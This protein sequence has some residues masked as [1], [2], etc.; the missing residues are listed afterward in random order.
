MLWHYALEVHEL[1]GMDFL[2]SGHSLKKKKKSY[3]RLKFKIAHLIVLFNALRIYFQV[4]WQEVGVKV[5]VSLF[6]YYQFFGIL[7]F[8]EKHILILIQKR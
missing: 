3:P 6:P 4:P 2:H 5:A 7:M 1:L 8:R